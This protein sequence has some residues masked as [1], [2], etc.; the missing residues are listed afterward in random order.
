MNHQIAF[1]EKIKIKL[2]N[3]L[4]KL[5]LEADEMQ[6]KFG[7]NASWCPINSTTTPFFWI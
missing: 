7:F 3:D 2:C 1:F 5:A 6:C 4:Y